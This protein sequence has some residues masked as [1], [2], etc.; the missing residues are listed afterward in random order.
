VCEPA[1]GH[2]LHSSLG[3]VH[4]KRAPR[5]EAGRLRWCRPLA[6]S[7]KEFRNR[8]FKHLREP[9]EHV[10]RR[11]FLLLL[12]TIDIGP[13][14]VGVLFAVLFLAPFRYRLQAAF[15]FCSR[16]NDATDQGVLSKYVFKRR[17]TKSDPSLSVIFS[18]F[19]GPLA[20]PCTASAPEC[21]GSWAL[22]LKLV[23]S[24]CVA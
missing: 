3:T 14:H 7:S 10:Y 15:G 1:L 8:D 21:R 24:G 16:A 4:V 9:I 6:R 22:A 11:I 2:H 12:K 18:P 5:V 20:T 17:T 13:V 23:I 19:N